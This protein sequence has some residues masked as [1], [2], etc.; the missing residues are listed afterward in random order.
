MFSPNIIEIKEFSEVKFQKAAFCQYSVGSKGSKVKMSVGS[1]VKMM[2][3]YPTHQG[4]NKHGVSWS[5]TTPGGPVGARCKSW[6]T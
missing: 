3:C 6:A 4:S 2:A 1:K 5:L